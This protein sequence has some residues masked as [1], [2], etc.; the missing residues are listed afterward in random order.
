MGAGHNC[1]V[2]RGDKID[3]P[4]RERQ[5]YRA[6][7]FTFDGLI[8]IRILLNDLQNELDRR[9]DLQFGLRPNNKPTHLLQARP[10]L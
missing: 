3:N 7:D 10:K 5:H 6:P 8:L 1:N 9:G 4:I 2:L